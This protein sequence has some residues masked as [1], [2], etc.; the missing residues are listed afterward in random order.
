MRLGLSDELVRELASLAPWGLKIARGRNDYPWP[1]CLPRR[2]VTWSV[3]ACWWRRQKKRT[4]RSVKHWAGFPS[5]GIAYCLREAGARLADVEHVAVLA[6][7]RLEYW[8]P[9]SGLGP[10]CRSFFLAPT[11]HLVRTV[12]Q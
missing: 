7:L 10:G 8:R 5:N 2:L 9:L 1:Q 11:K 3:T 4:F 12:R 6:P